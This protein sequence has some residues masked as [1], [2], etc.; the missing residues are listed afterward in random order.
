LFERSL[1]RDM[2][3]VRLLGVGAARLA[4]DPVVQRGLLDEEVRQKQSAVGR[5]V[6]AIRRQFGRGAIRRGSRFGQFDRETQDSGG[7]AKD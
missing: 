4:R 5:A 7:P 3:P 2:L 6:G 1:S